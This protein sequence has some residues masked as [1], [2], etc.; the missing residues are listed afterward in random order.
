[1][2]GLGVRLDDIHVKRR[3]GQNWVL[4][5]WFESPQQFT[6]F[7]VCTLSGI[8]KAMPRHCHGARRGKAVAT[9]WH[10]PHGTRHDTAMTRHKRARSWAAVAVLSPLP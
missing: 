9:P 5:I 1:M 3:R 7:R 2:F 8:F 10:A 6:L 4:G